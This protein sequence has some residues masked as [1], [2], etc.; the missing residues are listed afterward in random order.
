MLR[1]AREGLDQENRL[2]DQELLQ[3]RD[4]ARASSDALK[5][6]EAKVRVLEQ[7]VNSFD[8]KQDEIEFY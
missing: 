3:M 5:T 1:R 2:R 8:Q 4:R 6:F 7:Q